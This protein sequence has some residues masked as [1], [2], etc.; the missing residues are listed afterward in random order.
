V[1]SFHTDSV[2]RQI[3]SQFQSANRSSDNVRR[4][5]DDQIAHHRMKHFAD[6]YQEFIGKFGFDDKSLP[7]KA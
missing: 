4:S 5:F 7:K 1:L 3:I 6:E 2:G